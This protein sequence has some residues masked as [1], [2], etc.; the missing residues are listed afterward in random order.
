MITPEQREELAAAAALD[1]LD[2]DDQDEWERLSMSDPDARKLAAEF[3][4]IAALLVFCTPSHQPPIRS[5]QRLNRLIGLHEQKPAGDMTLVPLNKS[6]REWKFDMLLPWAAV[7]VFALASSYMALQVSRANHR[8]VE[9]H[10]RLLGPGEIRTAFLKPTEESEP[11]LAQVSFCARM[12]QGRLIGHHFK[13]IPPHQAYQLWLVDGPSGKV[14]SAGTFRSDDSGLVTFDFSPSL[15]IEK[16]EKALISL[17]KAG[18]VPVAEGPV[19]FA[20]F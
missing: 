4:N 8:V 10:E 9:L 5:K 17:E 11:S 7:L 1:A 14:V 20:G 16:L 18:G 3:E 13:T 6:S 19:L 12:Q 2:P 15:K